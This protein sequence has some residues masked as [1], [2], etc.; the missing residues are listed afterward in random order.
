MSL[1][2]AMNVALSGIQYA[3]TSTSIYANNLAN[4]RTDG[5]KES[6]PTAEAQAVG[7]VR[8]SSIR[9]NESQGSIAA[10]VE[11][12]NTDIAANILAVD[13]AARLMK[14]S[15]AALKTTGEMFDSL[16]LLG[17]NKD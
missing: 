8:L 15:M 1:R 10:G 6:S 13:D 17:R 7:G 2:S 14:T 12:S 9:T 16:L 5:F 3:S 4:Q 11:L